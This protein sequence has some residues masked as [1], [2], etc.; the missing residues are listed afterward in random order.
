MADDRV[1]AAPRL[2][3]H[4]LDVVGRRHVLGVGGLGA[5]IEPMSASIGE[6]ITPSSKQRA[7]SSAMIDQEAGPDLGDERPVGV[8]GLHRARL[9]FQARPQPLRAA[10]AG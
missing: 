5:L 6:A 3:L 4:R 9:A 2:I 7:A 8:G 10:L 1:E